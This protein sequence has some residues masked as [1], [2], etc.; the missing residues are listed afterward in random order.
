MPTVTEDLIAGANY[1]I[2]RE[3]GK[4]VTRI[5]FVEGLDSTTPGPTRMS[6]ACAAIG[7]SPGQFHPSIGGVAVEEINAEPYPRGSHTSARVVFTYTEANAPLPGPGTTTHTIRIS[8]TVRG[9]RTMFSYATS[10]NGKPAK[11]LK[12]EPITVD[13]YPPVA[14]VTVTAGGTTSPGSRLVESNKETSYAEAIKQHPS[15]LL[16]FES[17]ETANPYQEAATYTGTVNFA[18]WQGKPPRTWMYR[19]LNAEQ[20]GWDLRNPK[21]KVTRSF[22]YEDLGKDGGPNQWDPIVVFRDYNTNR[23]PHDIKPDQSRD[24]PAAGSVKGWKR[25]YLYPP[26]NF[27]DLGL[28]DVTRALR[29]AI[30][31]R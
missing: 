28:P 19:S 31:R 14:D 27:N 2:H 16:E 6:D 22:Q 17:V 25:V 3:S 9:V 20:I 26:Q 5:F 13:Y 12:L 7:I 10:I 18:D 11:V 24:V 21:F 30:S 8:S 1:R 15:L 29:N 4:K 23:V